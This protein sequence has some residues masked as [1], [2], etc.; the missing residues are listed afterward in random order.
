MAT[1]IIVPFSVIYFTHEMISF[2]LII[3][4]V[5]SRG[6][7]DDAFAEQRECVVKSL[8]SESR[9]LAVLSTGGAPAL[10][11]RRVDVSIYP[12]GTDQFSRVLLVKEVRHHYSFK[13][14]VKIGFQST[15]LK[16]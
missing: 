9:A 2:T 11:S 1:R 4:P 8:H 6:S 7:L 12:P 5:P 14:S 13:F 3:V 10:R 15:I 16:W